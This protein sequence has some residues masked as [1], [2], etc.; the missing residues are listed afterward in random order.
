MRQ[1]FLSKN[2]RRRGGIH[3]HSPGWI[4]NDELNM[5]HLNYFSTMAAMCTLNDGDANT[6]FFHNQAAYQK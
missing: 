3:D 5:G 1:L 2:Q 4:T 6:F